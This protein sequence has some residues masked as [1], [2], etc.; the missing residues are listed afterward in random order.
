MAS[1]L[2]YVG[3]GGMTDVTYTMRNLNY[4]VDGNAI[5]ACTIMHW[6]TAASFPV[7]VVIEDDQCMHQLIGI[8]DNFPLTGD[9][10]TLMELIRFW[11]KRKTHRHPPADQHQLSEIWEDENGAI[12][13]CVI[14]KFRD[15]PEQIAM[16]LQEW[17][18]QFCRT[19]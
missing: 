16:I 18:A 8:C 15:N 1:P 3:F 10:P 14:H 2:L 7:L 11:G 19:H 5:H 4:Y 9:Q 6:K 13:Q 17:I 12:I